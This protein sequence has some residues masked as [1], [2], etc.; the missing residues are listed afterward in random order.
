MNLAVCTEIFFFFLAVLAVSL[1]PEY[2]YWLKWNI[3]CSI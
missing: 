1:P 3:N 2:A